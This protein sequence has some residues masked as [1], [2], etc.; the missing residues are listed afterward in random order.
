[1]ILQRQLVTAEWE[2]L[3]QLCRMSDLAFTSTG[4]GLGLQ[5]VSKLPMSVVDF[6]GSLEISVNFGRDVRESGVIFL[7]AS[8]FRWGNCRRNFQ[9]LEHSAMHLC[10]T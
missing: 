3:R 10:S 2:I 1:M 4:P 9:R 8:P 7:T 6:S 5:C